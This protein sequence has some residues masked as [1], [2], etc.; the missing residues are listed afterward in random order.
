MRRIPIALAV[1]GFLSVFFSAAFNTCIIGKFAQT[2]CPHLHLWEYLPVGIVLASL[3][4][5]GVRL[6]R[7]R[8]IHEH[9][10]EQPAVRPARATQHDRAFEFG[11]ITAGF[12]AALGV[13][14]AIAPVIIHDWYVFP[15]LD[16]GLALMLLMLAPLSR[17]WLGTALSILSGALVLNHWFG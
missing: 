13:R 1:V 3:V 7:Q 8:A 15:R 14:A 6:A 5:T 12:F 2:G 16:I 4:L 17:S 11:I 9:I 10:F